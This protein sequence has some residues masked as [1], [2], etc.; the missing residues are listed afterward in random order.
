MN[1]GNIS[2][3][4]LQCA[5]PLGAAIG[6][7]TAPTCIEDYGEWRRL[8]IQ[9]TLNG[10]VVNEITIG[11]DD[12]ALLATWTALSIAADSTKAVWLTTFANPTNDGGE[13]REAG[14]GPGGATVF[15]GATPSQFSAEFQQKEQD[16]IRSYRAYQC[17][18]NL[19]VFIVT[20]FGVILGL[21]DAATAVTFRGIPMES[22][23]IGPKKP[24]QLSAL[25]MNMVNW[26]FLG[27]WSDWLHAVT[28]TDFDPLL[29]F[30]P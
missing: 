2:P 15:K 3:F 6:D 27:E 30:N 21:K 19:S 20:E 8:I 17:E 26:A 12:P 14:T 1:L 9:R 25:D 11:T 24:G 23:F 18:P 22:F 5:C 10:A 29:A 4:L 16:V 7:P 28:P 13:G